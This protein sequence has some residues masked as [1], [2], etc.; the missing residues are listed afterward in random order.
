MNTVA[1]KHSNEALAFI[2][3]YKTMPPDVKQEVKVMIENETENEE[4]AIFTTMSFQ[5]WDAEE[6][7]TSESELWEKFSNNQKDV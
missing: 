2:T 6:D 1:V 5:S 7:V 4:A 3:L